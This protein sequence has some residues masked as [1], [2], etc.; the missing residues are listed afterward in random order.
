MI[1][2]AAIAPD[3]TIYVGSYDGHL[4]ALNSTGTQKWAFYAGG[5]VVSSPAVGANGNVYF[6]SNNGY[7]YSVYPNGTLEWKFRTDGVVD[8]SPAIDSTGMIYF[9]SSNG[10]VYALDSSGTLIWKFNTGGYLGTFLWYNQIQQGAATRIA[11]PNPVLSCQGKLYFTTSDGYLYALG[12][13]SSSS[14]SSASCPTTSS[15]ISTSSSPTGFDWSHAVLPVMAL[16]TVVIIGAASGV[17]ILYRRKSEGKR[18][19]TP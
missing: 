3:G 14:S 6:G 10:V 1:S 12:S 11:S 5:P 4:Y 15:T 7:L 17:S 18:P 13:N 8:S 19:S 9:G 16:A 2:S